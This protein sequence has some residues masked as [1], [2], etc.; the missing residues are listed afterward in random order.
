MIVAVSRDGCIGLHGRIPWHYSGDL[1]RFKAVTLGTTIVMGHRT[2]LSIGARVLPD[3][4]NIVVTRSKLVGVECFRSLAEALASASG[5]VWLIGGAGIYEE[6]LRYC[7][8]IDMTLVPDTIGHPDAVRFPDIPSED[9]ERGAV[10]PHEYDA[11]LERVTYTRKRA[12]P[13]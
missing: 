11:R 13:T 8:V 9:W 7:D 10:V 1:K 6:G 3:R 4:R 5:D 12:Q 2:W